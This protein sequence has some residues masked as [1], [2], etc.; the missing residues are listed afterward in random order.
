MSSEHLTSD[1]GQHRYVRMQSEPAMTSSHSYR[2]QGPDPDWIF[3]ELPKATIVSVSRPDASDITPMLLS[4]TIEFR[5]KQKRV[6]IEEFH[7][8]Q[9]Q[10]VVV[11]VVA[12]SHHAF[13]DVNHH[14]PMISSIP[15]SL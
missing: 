13:G 12:P 9:E 5:Y 8:K 4:Y 14:T 2:Q 6:I 11:V 7:E 10:V 1:R 3:E 15:S